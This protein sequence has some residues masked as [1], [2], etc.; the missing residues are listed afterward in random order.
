M[1]QEW[2]YN[3][4]FGHDFETANDGHGTSM[5][6]SGD[7]A[8]IGISGFDIPFANANVGAILVLKFENN[9]WI[10]DTLIVNPDGG[11]DDYFGKSVSI[12][13]N[14]IVVGTV[15]DDDN[16][17]NSGSASVFELNT[18]TGIWSLTQKLG[19]AVSASLDN[20]G[21]TVAIDGDWIAVAATGHDLA[22]GNAGIVDMFKFEGGSWVHKTTIEPI[23]QQNNL[24]FGKRL[25]L[26]NDRL[27]IGVPSFDS[28]GLNDVGIVYEFENNLDSWGLNTQIVPAIEVNGGEFGESIS[29]EGDVLVVGSPQGI[30]AGEDYGRFYVFNWNGNTSVWDQAHLIDNPDGES[31]DMFGGDVHV[32]GNRVVVGSSDSGAGGFLD[33]GSVYIYEILGASIDLKEKLYSPVVEGNEQ[34]GFTVVSNEDYI[35]VGAPYQDMDEINSG[36]TDIFKYCKS[37]TTFLD[38]EVCTN[39]SFTFPDGLIVD[40]L[41]TSM[42][43]HSNLTNVAGCDS[44]VSTNLTVNPLPTI[45]MSVTNA[46]CGELNGAVD[47]TVTG[48]SSI[49]FLWNNGTT[50]EDLVDV[51]ANSYFL[52]ATN[53]FGCTSNKVANVVSSELAITGTVTNN[54]CR[55]LTVGAID[56]SIIGSASPFEF[57]WTNGAES[58]DLMNL[59]SGE[60]EVIVTDMNGCQ[61]TASFQVSQ[62]DAFNFSETVTN[63][64]CG[65]ADGEIDMTVSGGTGNLDFD[66]RNSTNTQVATDEDLIG[67]GQGQ[68]TLNVTDENGCSDAFIVNISEDG[69]PS[70]ILDSVTSASCLDDGALFTSIDALNG[71]NTILWSNSETTDDMTNLSDGS[72]SVTVTD[73]SG[74]IGNAI[75]N[76]PNAIPTLTEICLVTVDQATNTNLIVWEKPVTTDISSFVVYRESSV[77]GQYQVIDTVAYSDES[78]LTDSTAFPQIRSWKYKVGTINT[79]GVESQLSPIHKTIHCA[80]SQGLGGVYNI[81]WDN[82]GGF[83]YTTYEVWRHT[84]TNGWEN[85]QSI[86]LGNNS[87]TDTPPE[88]NELDYY[89][90]IAS[91]NTCSTSKAND[92]NSSRS[93]RTA[94]VFEPIDQTGIEEI[95][96]SNIKLYPNP[97]SNEIRLTYDSHETVSIEL[98]D[99][100]GKLLKLIDTKSGVAI[101]MASLEKGVYFLSFKLNGM[102]YKRKIVKQ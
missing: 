100:Q 3:S 13:G 69:G 83:P 47:A 73:N 50:D 6:I 101:N 23:T 81:F 1:G 22:W 33:A 28:G 92:Y 63:A 86:S 14:R 40:H 48:G 42:V 35:L 46:T 49:T 58:E 88:T 44:V 10:K 52:T 38:S 17:S 98:Y 78:Q 5:D 25:E 54:P 2:L 90:A 102:N 67:F 45:S 74:C 79:C 11:Y 9:D 8:V 60:Y 31:D 7:Y 66:W 97:F 57:E 27:I 32:H 77:A 34:F 95:L 89:V 20:F 43:H 51:G 71:V 21:E 12:S 59:A 29:L 99:V 18:G 93:N 55:G 19:S 36:V 26:E 61:S 41:T 30:L 80:I 64:T 94:G 56:L 39:E 96:N 68:Y 4:T 75:F 70:I 84:A 24:S 65:S 82:Y 53:E 16:G 85:I 62:P 15:L 91:P 37:D 72:Y 76:V 87:Y